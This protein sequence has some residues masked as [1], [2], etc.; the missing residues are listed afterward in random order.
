MISIYG[1]A[2]SAGPHAQTGFQPPSLKRKPPFEIQMALFTHLYFPRL[3]QSVF[4]DAT[5]EAVILPQHRSPPSGY[6]RWG[7]YP[8]CYGIK[9]SAQEQR[10]FVSTGFPFDFSISSQ[11]DMGICRG[12]KEPV[13]RF[14]AF[15]VFPDSNTRYFVFEAGSGSCSGHGMP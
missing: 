1:P 7:C 5:A 2:R 4:H 12:R 11:S 3:R 6:Q 13:R 10:W 15:I 8:L 9:F 14:S